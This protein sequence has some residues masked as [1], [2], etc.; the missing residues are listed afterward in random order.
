AGP[1]ARDAAAERAIRPERLY[2]HSRRLRRSRR[3]FY[4]ARLRLDGARL[5]L[6][7]N[8][9]RDLVG[10]APDQ[11]QTKD[12]PRPWRDELGRS[13]AAMLRACRPIRFLPETAATIP[14]WLPDTATRRSRIP[15]WVRPVRA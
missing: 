3:N 1:G 13:F 7:E 10:R 15:H 2:F 5:S 14:A 12:R 6:G 4:A 9:G 11:R 8:A